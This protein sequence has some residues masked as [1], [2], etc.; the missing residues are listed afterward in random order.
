AVGRWALGC[1][2][3]RKV[4]KNLF[5]GA[6]L[7]DGEELLFRTVGDRARLVV[8]YHVGTDAAKLV[9]RLMARVIPGAAVGRARN[10]C[11][12]SLVAWRDGS[13]PEARWE[14]LVAC[15]EVEIRL[16]QALLARRARRR[17]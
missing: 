17:K 16:V 6:S 1:F 2:D 8:D 15:H 12:V 5:R 10:S 3:T 11:L 14:R 13:M 7:F 9:P 4:G